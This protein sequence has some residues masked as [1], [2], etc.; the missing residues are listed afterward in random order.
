LTIDLSPTY[1]DWAGRNF[2][3]NRLDKS[4]HQLLRADVL[5]FLAEPGQAAGS[6]DLIVLDPPTFSNSKKMRGTL[7]VER[8]HPWLIGQALRLLGPGGTLLFSTNHRR[9]TLR[10]SD[11]PTSGTHGTAELRIRDIAA[12]TLPPDFHNP[13]TRCCYL[14]TRVGN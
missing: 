12:D 3:E 5:D 6:F 14:L 9:F 4:R 13:R 2:A 10:P 1:L 11:I 8:D 7:D